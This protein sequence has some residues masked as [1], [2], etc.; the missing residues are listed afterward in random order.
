MGAVLLVPN[1][2][3]A[4]LTVALDLANRYDANWFL[5]A[6]PFVI[7]GLAGW[8]ISIVWRAGVTLSHAFDDERTPVKRERKVIRRLFASQIIAGVVVQIL[9]TAGALPVFWAIS[10]L[11]K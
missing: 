3:G 9:V 7:V 4:I 11:Q 10:R 5:T 2:A 8:V 6:Y 1:I